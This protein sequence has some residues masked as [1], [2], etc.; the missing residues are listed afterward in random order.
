MK[1]IAIDVSDEGVIDRA[2]RHALQTVAAELRHCGV[3]SP[4]ER[5]VERLVFKAIVDV[6]PNRPDAAWC[7]S[8]IEERPDLLGMPVAGG[9]LNG[10]IKHAVEI[11]IG[12]S[13]LEDL[14]RTQQPGASELDGTDDR[15]PGQ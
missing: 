9:L 10:S 13:V 7:R 12:Q 8:A 4:D 2:T 1:G 3:D 15:S 5:F 6:L 14:R 11:T